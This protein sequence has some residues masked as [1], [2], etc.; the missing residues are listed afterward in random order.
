MG[1]ARGTFDE[2]N[3]EQL[4]AFWSLLEKATKLVRTT[5]NPQGLNVGINEGDAAGA[6]VPEHLHAH[7]VPRWRGDTNFMM[8]IGG[9][10]VAPDALESVARAY[11]ESIAAGALD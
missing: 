7:V 8:V 4:A 9:V 5:L 2:F 1:E 6:G 11:R 10:R 3:P